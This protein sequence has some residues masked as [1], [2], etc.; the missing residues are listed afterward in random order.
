MWIEKT[1]DSLIQSSGFQV[2]YIMVRLQ[3]QMKRVGYS[4]MLSY[5]NDAQETRLANQYF[6]YSTW[7]ENIIN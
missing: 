1:K 7:R 3:T 4:T 5:T 2:V 6:R